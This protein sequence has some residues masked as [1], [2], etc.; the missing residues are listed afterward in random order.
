[1]IPLISSLFFL[2]AKLNQKP[3][4]KESKGSWGIEQ[5]RKEWNSYGEKKD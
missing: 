5:S 3:D 4:V 2:S 1:L